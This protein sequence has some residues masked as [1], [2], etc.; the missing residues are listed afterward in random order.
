MKEMLRRMV[1]A[2]TDQEADRAL[3]VLRSSGFRTPDAMTRQDLR[4]FVGSFSSGDGTLSHRTTELLADG[5][6]R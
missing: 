3:R 1:D 4:S 6:G 2:M 5:F